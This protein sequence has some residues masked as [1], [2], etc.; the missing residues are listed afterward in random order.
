[1]EEYIDFSKII[2]FSKMFVDYISNFDKLSGFYTGNPFSE[3]SWDKILHSLT[4]HQYKREPLCRIL[5]EQ[6]NISGNDPKTLE[7]INSLKEK[8]CFAVVTGQQPG[9]FTGPLYT[10]YKALTAIKLSESLKK[11]YNHNFVPIFWIETNDHD[12]EEVRAVNLIAKDKSL[13]L[14][15]YQPEKE[16]LN[17]PI[18]EIT[19]D[20]EIDKILKNFYDILPD[21]EFK[22]DI[23]E[24][25]NKY[26]QKFISLS[27]AFRMVMTA[28]FKGTGLILLDPS[29]SE[30]KNLATD[31][32]LKIAGNREKLSASF[33]QTYQKLITLGY[34]PE[35]KIK[36]NSL[37]LFYHNSGERI[38]IYINNEDI[39][40]GNSK[41]IIKRQELIDKIIKN[42]E[43]FSPN[44]LTR[45]I[46][47][48]FLL[49]TVSYVAGPTEVCYFSQISEAY[50]LM[51]IPMPVIF[52]RA[53][54]T[55]IDKKID[56]TL[57]KYDILPSELMEKRNILKDKLTKKFILPELTDLFQES[58]NNIKKVYQKIS[59]TAEPIDI[60]LKKGIEN[61]FRKIFYQFNKIKNRF[62]KKIQEKH[63]IIKSETE[64]INNF[65]FP[66]GKLQERR[67]NIFTFISR[68]GLKFMKFLFTEIDIYSK[69]HQLLFLEK[70]SNKE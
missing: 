42:P 23:I 48:D 5:K 12:F 3:Q 69:K 37:N 51:E 54:I 20:N 66:S 27:F 30:L 49:P 46:I 21:N 13:T 67:I 59:S 65:I 61:S 25:L 14:L 44:V 22:I 56:N 6:N 41:A 39:I 9:I 62:E 58:E 47:Q 53:S 29:D 19:F 50:K 8:N 1:M 10:I 32:F 15:K 33:D 60:T 4:N 45:P 55:I 16:F 63:S 52:P 24:L 57:K 2:G 40:I 17:K 18:G 11:R 70:L 7:N 28:V 38:P 68:Y 34:H 35:V 26:H 31:I 43:K 64:E 36:E